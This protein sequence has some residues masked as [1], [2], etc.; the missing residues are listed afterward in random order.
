MQVVKVP[1]KRKTCE[2]AIQ[3]L[4]ERDLARSSCISEAPTGELS[5]LRAPRAAVLQECPFILIIF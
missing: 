5:V 4:M 1:G 2:L 3:V